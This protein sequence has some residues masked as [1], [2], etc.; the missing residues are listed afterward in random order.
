MPSR[1][2]KISR[3]E[4]AEAAADYYE[5]HDDEPPDHAHHKSH[6]HNSNSDYYEYNPGPARS[7][8]RRTCCGM[9]CTC[10]R[11]VVS[12][13]MTLVSIALLW[14]VMGRPSWSD[15]KATLGQL[16]V[17]DFTHVLGN[18]SDADWDAGFQEDPNAGSSY[19][20]NGGDGSMPDRENHIWKQARGNGLTLTLQ[21]ALDETWQTEYEA[22]LADWSESEALTLS[23]V[24]VDVDHSCKPVTGLMKVC[25]GNFGHTGW[26]GINELQIVY[27]NG[28]KA[29][30]IE[31]SVAKMNEYYL[32]NAAYA[33]RQYTMCH[34]IGHGFGLPHTDEDPNNADQGNCLDYTHRPANN[35]HPGQVNFDVLVQMYLPNQQNDDNGDNDN[36]RQLWEDQEMT[37]SSEGER[38]VLRRI[39]LWA[40]PE[41]EAQAQQQHHQQQ[42]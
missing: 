28:G 23:S 11:G 4:E 19:G 2:S 13:A 25:N 20:S 35:M 42:R 9:V 34:E 38:R 17:D 21:N 22:A 32:L 41:Q 40:T 16:D 3:Y 31:T 8:R 37:A 15:V 6:N 29:G 30:Y 27:Q 39:Y 12:L 18:L 36:N 10:V 5:H 33:Q 1:G 14:N 24:S 7:P 26:V